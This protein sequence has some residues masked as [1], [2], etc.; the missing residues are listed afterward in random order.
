HRGPVPLSQPG[1]YMHQT[2]ST[3]TAQRPEH[4]SEGQ[5][6]APVA[7]RVKKVRYIGLVGGLILAA[8]IPLMLPAE[9]NVAARI[10]AGVVV[11]MGTWWMPEAVPIPA[12]APLLLVVYQ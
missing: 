9:L 10:T 12:T 4:H 3:V 6:Q 2:G 8:F 5:L 1:V 11:L 7:S